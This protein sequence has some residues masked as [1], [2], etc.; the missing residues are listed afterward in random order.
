MILLD[1]THMLRRD[2]TGIASYARS[3]A[4]TFASAGVPTALL[5]DHRVPVTRGLGE[6][7]IANQ[8]FGNLPPASRT[9]WL[10][11][12]LIRSRF[13]LSRQV[14]GHRVET[15]MMRLASLDPSLPPHDRLFNAS[16]GMAFANGV[17]LLRKHLAEVVIPDKI[18]LAHWTGAAPIRLRGAPNVYTLHDVIPLQMPHLVLDRPGLAIRR[19]RAVAGAADHIVAVSERAREDIIEMLGLPAERVSVTYQP[20]PH[21]P[22]IDQE[23]SARLVRNVYAVQPGEYAFFCGALEPKKN[24]YRLIEAFT[25]SGVRLK[26]LLAGPL[27]WLHDDV[28]KL[29]EQLGA[30]ATEPGQLQVRWLGYLP[31]IHLAALMRCA[32]FFAFPSLYEGFGLPVVEAM[33][34]G[35]PVLTSAAGG[36]AEVAG[37]AALIVNPLDVSDMARKIHML[38]S[39]AYLRRE[40]AARGPVQAARFSLASHFERLALAYK[41]VGVTLPDKADLHAEVETAC[42]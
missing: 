17:F 26:L 13:G 16:N 38:A 11:E 15:A 24:L 4:S 29:L 41:Q 19:F 20:V 23:A 34:L 8:V 18:T 25:L 5:L 35:V 14:V 27:G 36:L 28:R 12:L 9:G 32:R 2:G 10:L 40:L 37:D 33:Q 31:R 22:P 21:S 6:I 1:G 42:T 3:L 7:G 39:D 30:N